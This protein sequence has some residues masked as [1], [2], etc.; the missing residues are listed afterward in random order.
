[1]KGFF[2]ANGKQ[3]SGKTLLMVKYLIDE[4]EQY[5]NK[6]I[7]SNTLLFGV[8]YQFITFDKSRDG[9]EN[10]LSILDQLEDDPNFF[11]H[12]IMLI[13]EIH[14]YLNSLDF[15]KNNNRKLQTFFS[16]L[17]KRDILLL[18]TAQYFHDIDIRVR[19]QA[20]NS[21]E[22]EH[23]YKDLFEATT[24]KVLRYDYI[25]EEITKLKL[26]EYYKFYDTEYLILE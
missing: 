19:S 21:F 1:M 16:Q 2:F 4:H 14:L 15:F 25:P 20:L 26:S 13:D 5:P 17:R 12:S 18:G 8:N 24:C 10:K 9:E 6:K 7:F 22:M 11:N 23:I 3:G